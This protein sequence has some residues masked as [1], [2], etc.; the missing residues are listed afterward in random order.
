MTLE[1]GQEEQGFMGMEVKVM[2]KGRQ[3]G[4]IQRTWDKVEGHRWI[5]SQNLYWLLTFSHVRP[6]S[7]DDVKTRLNEGAAK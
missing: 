4:T 2:I 1:Y 7:L 5:P 6:G 3:I